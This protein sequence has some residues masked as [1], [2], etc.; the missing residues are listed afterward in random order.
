MTRRAYAHRKN[1]TLQKA[2]E[3]HLPSFG[4]EATSVKSLKKLRKYKAQRCCAM[5][6]NQRQ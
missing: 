3:K 6:I 4:V 2:V 5:H 1:S